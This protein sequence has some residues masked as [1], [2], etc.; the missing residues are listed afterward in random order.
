M[1]NNITKKDNCANK[2]DDIQ[3]YIVEMKDKDKVHKANPIYL[4]NAVRNMSFGFVKVKTD[5]YAMWF[6]A[7]NVFS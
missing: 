5:T 7:I 3:V 6:I 2:E 1:V 4:K